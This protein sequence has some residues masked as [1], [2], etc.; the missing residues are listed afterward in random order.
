MTIPPTKEKQM[1][2]LGQHIDIVQ[3][4]SSPCPPYHGKK[5]FRTP[6]FVTVDLFLCISIITLKIRAPTQTRDALGACACS[7]APL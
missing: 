6:Q 3:S 5:H 2:S 1:G 4:G 7:S